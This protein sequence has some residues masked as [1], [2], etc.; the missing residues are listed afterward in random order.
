MT[1][2]RIRE[3]GEVVGDFRPAFPNVSFPSPTTE[4]DLDYVGVDLVRDGE[5]PFVS[6][7]QYTYRDGVEQ[8][9]GKWFT[10]FSVAEHSAEEVAEIT[11]RQWS[12]IRKQRNTT[13]SDCDWTQLPDAPVN[14]V[15]WATYRQALRDITDQAD[16][17]NIAWPVAPSIGE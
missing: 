8:I 11:L 13:L 17:F 2:Y 6:P 7:F 5:Q 1:E 15:E 16:P 12:A 10:K 3:T 4:E 14:A 9:E